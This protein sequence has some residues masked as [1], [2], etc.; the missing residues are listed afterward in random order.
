MMQDGVLRIEVP[1]KTPTETE[2]TKVEVK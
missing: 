1:K 2:E